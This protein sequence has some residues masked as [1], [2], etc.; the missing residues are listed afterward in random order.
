MPAIP[1]PT[2]TVPLVDT[3]TTPE[4]RAGYEAAGRWTEDTLSRK[5]AEAARRVPDRAAVIDGATGRTHTYAELERDANRVADHLA[6]RLGVR[7]G[8]VVAVQ[9]P[10]WYETVA[11]QMGVLRLGAVLNPML[12]IYREREMAH[13]LRTA[14]TRVL[15][16]PATYRRHDHSAMAERLRAD[17]ECLEHTLTIA[18]PEGNGLP[19]QPF[20]AQDADRPFTGA[21][22]SAVSELLFTSGTEALPKA[23]MHTEQTASVGTRLA[24]TALGITD[25]DVVWMPSP[26][27]HSTGFNYGVRMA[28]Y[29][30]LPLVLQDRWDG[31][32][33]AD[34]VQ[35]HRISY[36]VAASTFLSDLV[37]AAGES[38]N[39]LSSLRLFSS[40]G[41]P[42]P[43]ALIEQAEALGVPVLRLYGSTELLVA[44]WNRPESPREKRAR[45]DGC[46]LP[47]VELEVRVDGRPVLGEP[48]EIHVRGPSTCVG[49]FA[50]PERT[51]AT[52]DPAGWVASGDLGVL[53]DDGYLTIVGRKKEI[54]IRGGLNV[55]P[56]ELEDL[57]GE[58]PQ[59]ARVAVIPLPDD[60]LGE[61]GCACVV[62]APGATLELDD[63][64]THLNRRGV[65][66]FKH[67]ERLVVLAE[68]PTTPTGKVQ[69]HE[70]VRALTE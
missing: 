67:P 54:I 45:T 22:A 4:R 52:I 60:R 21:T 3:V 42:V 20:W 19:A 34:L 31:A 16:T 11:V 29:H 66:R 51:A 59:V 24:A 26:I 30:G 2:N 43:T 17:V 40:G 44:T 25:A 64:V 23:V 62:P 49:F 41:A 15:I 28:V 12:P 48:G 57:I 18:D 56:R 32:A 46:A 37:R 58:M 33:A 1:S 14:R 35:R 68:L 69:K 10:N 8:E 65:A 47:D 13:M 63:V 6:R 55:A 9:L 36:T 27:G 38:G 5:L 70:L 7:A 61:I 50:D 39:D 53:D